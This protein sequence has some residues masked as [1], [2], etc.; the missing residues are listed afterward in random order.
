MGLSTQ[1][2]CFALWKTWQISWGQLKGTCLLLLHTRCVTNKC[3]K[4]G[5]RTCWTL[6]Q[7]LSQSCLSL[8]SHV[9][10]LTCLSLSSPIYLSSPFILYSPV[11]LIT[12]EC[13]LSFIPF[14]CLS[15]SSRVSLFLTLSL[16][17]FS[18][19]LPTHVY[20]SLLICL[21]VPEPVS[22][23]FCLHAYLF[24]QISVM[25]LFLRRLQVNLRYLTYFWQE[26]P[27]LSVW[28]CWTSVNLLYIYK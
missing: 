7:L 3:D 21:S 17:C 26:Q 28:I 12:S 24:F 11:W 8:C 27:A 14:F 18:L 19:S 22:S 13:L 15:M 2:T 25:N 5:M 16:S 4:L 20:A 9:C 10:L 23:V 1:R 6:K